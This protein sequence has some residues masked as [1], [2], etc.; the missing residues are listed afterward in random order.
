VW[1]RCVSAPSCEWV[2]MTAPILTAGPVRLHPICVQDEDLYLRLHASVETMRHVSAV[3][4]A[5]TARLRFSAVCRLTES[6]DPTYWI[7]SVSLSNQA[8]DV[9]IA[10]LMA[11]AS[12]A[13]V[14]MMLLP[15]WQGRGVGKHVIQAITEYGFCT[16]GVARVEA[17]QRARNVGWERLM[18]RS[19]FMRVQGGIISQDWIRWRRDRD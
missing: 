13:E 14:G 15:E 4:D 16:L 3:V 12:S 18:E 9:G 19:G 8:R 11:S 2:E 5:D 6:S 1:A 17:R 10:S 7:W